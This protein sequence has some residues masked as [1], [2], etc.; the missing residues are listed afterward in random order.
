M[1]SSRMSFSANINYYSSLFL[2]FLLITTL[3]F[4]FLEALNLE[5]DQSNIMK[6]LGSKVCDEIYVVEEG[7][8]L[9]T[10]SHKCNDPFILE[11]NTQINDDDDVFP[12]LVLKITSSR[13]LGQLFIK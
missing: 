6:L 2:L 9:Q 4:S 12:G 13:K 5:D 11:E 3:M 10:I 7:E 8:S 1:A